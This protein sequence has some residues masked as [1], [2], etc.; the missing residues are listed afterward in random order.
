MNKKKAKKIFEQYNPESDVV[1]CPYGKSDIRKKLDIY[2]TAAVNLYGVISLDDFV[3]IFNA[4]NSVQTNS[5]EIY[6]LLLPLVLKKGWYAFYK[7]YIVHFFFFKDFDQVEYLL[8]HQEDKPRYIPEKKEFH[9]Y[10]DMGYSDNDCWCN[11]FDF[12]SETFGS[13]EETLQAYED[14]RHIITFSN[15]MSELDEILEFYNLEFEDEDQ[16]QEFFD[17]LMHAKTYTRSWQTNGN[18]PAEILSH[19]SM[20]EK[21]PVPVSTANRPKVGRNDPCTC[22]SGKKYKRCCARYNKTKSAQ[23]SDEDVSFFFETWFGLLNFVNKKKKVI[24]TLIEPEYPDSFGMQE[25]YKIRN[26]IWENPKL[27]DEYIR[28]TRLP[29]EKVDILKLWRKK[30][31]KGIFFVV[32]Y[33]PEYVVLVAPDEKGKDRLYGVKGLK[34]SIA[35]A[36]SCEL[37]TCIDTVLLPFKGK[38]IYDGFLHVMPIDFLEGAKE[39]LQEIY[40]ISMKHGIIESL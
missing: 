2:A 25:S 15:D 7:E 30:H 14:V 3:N 29:K 24:K 34:D 19:F 4:Q 35:T 32:K 21:N 39:S 37:P 12:M 6:V 26:V 18:T 5:E 17:L 1:R 27:I 40:D 33:E 16:L 10:E 13:D 9:K 22:G 20:Q 28:E 8:Q 31:M 38:I 11:V 23:L 36:L